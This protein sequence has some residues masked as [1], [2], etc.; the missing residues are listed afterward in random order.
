M[1]FQFKAALLA[2]LGMG[3]MTASAQ[4]A[5]HGT[6][7][8]A[9]ANALP[10]ARVTKLDVTGKTVARVNGAVLT[11]RDL[12]R[13]M[14]LI[15][16][17]AKQHNGFPEKLEPEIRK[18]ALD[19][20]IFE[21]L[22]YQE[23]KHRNMN[24]SAERMTRAERDFRKQFPSPEIYSQFI[25]EELNGSRQVLRE[26]IRRSL[27]IES[28]LNEEVVNKSRVTPA[29]VRSFYEKNPGKFERE[30]LFHIQTI[31]ILPPA[32]GGADVAK[33]AR[34]RAEDA[35]KQARTATTYKDFGLLAEKISDD[36]YR[37]NMGDH[38]PTGRDHLPPEVVKAALAMKPGQVSELIQ[39]G[40]A[41]TVV[42][43]VAHTP[44][45]RIPF[46]EVKGQ[47]QTDMQKERVE[48]LRTALGKKLRQNAKIET[49]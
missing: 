32:N 37:V 35:A 19:M 23:A 12:V 6:T 36:D 18:G 7:H 3:L 16:P 42:R 30:E 44:A 14:F 39:L 27:L 43:L 20:I 11:D 8:G 21:E 5:S 31:S 24:V 13:E 15:F 28:L 4:V 29:Q 17:Y 48:Q 22:V 34:R 40:T 46:A 25:K 9:A 33:E 26:K 10:P 38:K 2:L 1:R 45:G 47:V 41:Y 49:L